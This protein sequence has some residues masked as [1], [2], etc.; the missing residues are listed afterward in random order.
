MV[1]AE[2]AV[3][4][5]LQCPNIEDSTVMTVLAILAWSGFNID[6]LETVLHSLRRHMTIWIEMLAKSTQHIMN[7]STA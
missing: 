4:E 5:V 6:D 1:L 7:I 2:S 3:L